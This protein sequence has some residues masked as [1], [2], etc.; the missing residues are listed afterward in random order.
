MSK[1][2]YQW[3]GYAKSM[4]KRY[5]DKVNENEKKAVEMA[6]EKTLAMK[7]GETRMKVVEL[8]LIKHT[9]TIEGAALKAFC[10]E[11]AA[12]IYHTEFIREVG[13]CFHCDS[14]M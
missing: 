11:S 2:R 3:W 1:P 10:S 6:I 4:I 12:R 14:L 9:H 13:K 8:A 7:T 5:P